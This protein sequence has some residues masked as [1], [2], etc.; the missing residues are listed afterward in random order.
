MRALIRACLARV[1]RVRAICA[2]DVRYSNNCKLSNPII[3]LCWACSGRK[4]EGECR[5]R[6]RNRWI[7]IRILVNIKIKLK[8]NFKKLKKYIL[9]NREEILIIL[10]PK[11]KTIFRR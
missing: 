2:C 5:E 6:D 1:Q 9:L 10:S 8:L 4:D 7:L 11:R 3:S